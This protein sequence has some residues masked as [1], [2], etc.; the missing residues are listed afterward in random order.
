[1]FS[2]QTSNTSDVFSLWIQSAVK[3]NKLLH[4]PSVLLDQ[5][6]VFTCR[7]TVGTDVSFLWSFG[8]GSSRLGNATEHH[9]FNR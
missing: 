5:T 1:M 2:G 7:I 6:V 3:L 9:T 8:D 4:Q